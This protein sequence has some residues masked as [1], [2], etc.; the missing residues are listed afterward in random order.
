[1]RDNVR[2]FVEIA[3][4]TFELRGPIYE[5]GSYLVE[6]QH[7]RGDLRSI[8]AGQR[9][10]GCD[11]REGPGVDRVEDLAQLRLPD[12]SAQ[13]IICVDTLEHVF[14]LQRAM[15]EMLRVLAP[16][17]TIL[18]AAPFDFRVH[19]YPSDYWRLTPSCLARLLGPL[20]G[21]IVGWQGLESFPHTVFGM[22]VK[23]PA[24]EQFVRGASPFVERFDAWLQAEEVR[25]PWQKRLKHA[26]FGWLRSKG[27]RRRQQ[28]FY[29]A[30]FAMYLPL[31][32]NWGQ[33][34]LGGPH[35]SH[36]I[37]GRLNLSL[38]FPEGS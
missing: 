27:D 28:A 18:L 8:F 36:N 13:T 6:D 26:M 30:D 4:S 31:G 23:S 11:M 21:S 17:G 2:A 15:D 20:E 24:P 1:M 16:G 14:E 37:G 32:R 22:G 10:V 29:K 25:V 35:A 38:D 33:H 19:D 7:G 9:Y 12:E 3:A 5:F 34:L